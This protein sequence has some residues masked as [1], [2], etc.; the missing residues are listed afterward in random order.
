[1]GGQMAT[2]LIEVRLSDEI[3]NVLN[4]L[5]CKRGGVGHYLPEIERNL[6][7]RNVVYDSYELD[8]AINQLIRD[9]RINICIW[10]ES[11]DIDKKNLIYGVA[12]GSQLQV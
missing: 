3:L 6:K 5:N 11:D 12:L 9:S 2:K 10:R 8:C 1:M 7:L 4:E